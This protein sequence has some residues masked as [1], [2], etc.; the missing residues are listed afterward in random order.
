MKLVW[1]YSDRFKKG[2]PN[3][4]T[5]ATHN[6]IQYLYRKSI[7]EAPDSYQKIVFTD[8]YNFPLFN[9]LDVELIPAPKKEFIFLDDLKFDAAEIIDGEFIITDGDL[10]I[11]EELIVP[12]DY[13]IGFE[14]KIECNHTYLLK[15]MMQ[16]E[17]I[18]NEL[19]YWKGDNKNI[20]NLGLMYFNDNLL[21]S[22]LIK[23]YRNT[24]LFFSLFVDKKYKIN[25]REVLFG[26]AGCCMFTY[27]FLKSKNIPTFYFVDNNLNKYDH[28]GGPRK[29]QY[30]DEYY[31]SIN[32]QDNNRSPNGTPLI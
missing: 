16:N 30:L 5:I 20:N 21:K 27:Q 8:E 19:E 22:E 24:Q 1:T 29:L 3:K 7:K 25:E 10:F 12:P 13:K 15:E 28:L 6:Y 2:R 32:K 23:E 4:N 9:D 17:G 31:N 18:G 11:K 14:V 26:S